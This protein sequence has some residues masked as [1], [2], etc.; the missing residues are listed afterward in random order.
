MRNSHKSAAKWAR[1]VLDTDKS[2]DGPVKISMD[3]MYM[4]DR[5]RKFAENKWNPPYLVVVGH[6]MGRVWAYQT[7]NKGPYDEAGWLPSKL[8]ED[9]DGCGFKEMRIQLKN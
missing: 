1:L 2:V 3:C 7:P 9:W 4:H 5:S 8:I 6:R